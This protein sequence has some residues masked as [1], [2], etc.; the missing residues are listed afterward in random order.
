MT[1]TATIFMIIAMTLIWGGL[2]LSVIHLIR[3]PD[4]S[5]RELGFD[6]E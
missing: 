5:H 1:T 3:N 4:K 2:L 6:E